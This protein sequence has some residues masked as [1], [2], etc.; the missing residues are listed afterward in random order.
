MIGG[1][2]WISMRMCSS[3]GGKVGAELVGVLVVG[4]TGVDVG[5][6]DG[7]GVGYWVGT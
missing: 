4:L 3:T 1:S 2:V 5:C 7:V 6:N